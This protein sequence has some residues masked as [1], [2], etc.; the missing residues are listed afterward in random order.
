MINLRKL[1]VLM[2]KVIKKVLVFQ[3]KNIYPFDNHA[4]V[5][6][7]LKSLGLCLFPFASSPG[8]ILF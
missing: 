5:T 3:K 4:C 8:E 7:P 2:L 1:M 6:F